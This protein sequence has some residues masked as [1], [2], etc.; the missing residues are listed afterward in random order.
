[1]WTVISLVEVRRTLR[2]PSSRLRRVAASSKRA[3]AAS[4]GFFSCSSDN[5]VLAK[6]ETSGFIIGELCARML[7][8]W[9]VGGAAVLARARRLYG[10]LADQAC[11]SHP[12]QS[13]GCPQC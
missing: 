8:V 11:V 12:S 9:A 10:L 1:M 2:R 13:F 6:S 7:C 3:S 4:Q 5:V